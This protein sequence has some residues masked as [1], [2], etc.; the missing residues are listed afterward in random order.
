MAVARAAALVMIAF[1]AS[2][3]VGLVRQMVFGFYFGTG[4]EMS[5]YV[6]ASR[7]PEML[8]LVMA[9]GALGS[10]F[11]PTFT[12]RL[13]RGDPKAAW[14]LASAIINLLLVILVP[15]SLLTI[16]VAPWLVRT[17]VVPKFSPTLQAQTVALMRVM[18]LSTAIFG[19]SGIV[20]GVLN[21][22]QHFLLPAIA[23]IAYNLILIAGAVLGGLTNVGIMGPAWAM[24]V[25]AL[26]HLLVQ[27]PGLMRY[28]AH[29]VPAL[30]LDDP[31]VREVG[32]LMGPRV[33]GVAAVQLNFVVTN[34]LA[35]GLAGGAIAALDYAWRLMLL[36]QG[37]FAQAVGTAVFPTFAA[38][39]AS[40]DVKALRQTLSSMVVTVIAVTFPATVGLMVLGRPIIAMIFERGAFTDTSVTAVAGALSLFALGLVAH[41]LIEILAR[42]FY[43]LHDTWTPAVSA[44]IAVILNIGLGLMM[45]PMFARFGLPGHSGLALANSLA[46]LVEMGVLLVFI[47]LASSV[48]GRHLIGTTMPTTTDMA[49]DAIK[50]VDIRYIGRQTLRVMGATL[51]M[52][53]VLWLWLRLPLG[54]LLQVGGGMAIGVLGYAAFAAVFRVREMWEALAAIL[55]R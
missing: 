40:G 50:L 27:V 32:R 51:G 22:H 33:L 6:A 34:N 14:R 45:L 36:P 4:S 13:T 19:V 52:T 5:A 2:R 1:A 21:A 46:A 3:A 31:Y 10:A 23:P 39:A 25:G 28:Q 8:Y 38:Q 16:L 43:A 30:G 48:S 18:L 11:I 29:Y 15:L 55:K 37:I 42:A 54:L 12:A 7:I 17:V 44:V 49:P 24:V 35:S 26:F 9:G 53:M 47:S 41:S 20:M